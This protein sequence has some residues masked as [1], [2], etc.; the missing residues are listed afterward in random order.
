MSIAF[1]KKTIWAIVFLLILLIIGLLVFVNPKIL[2]MFSGSK[3]L[4]YKDIPVFQ[5]IG[6]TDFN[7]LKYQR[8]TIPVLGYTASDNGSFVQPA[9]QLV[10]LDSAKNIASISVEDRRI[11]DLSVTYKCFTQGCL[12]SLNGSYELS[13][14]NLYFI[15][16]NGLVKFETSMPVNGGFL[17]SASD[18]FLVVDKYLYIIEF[19][20]ISRIKRYDIYTGKLDLVKD[21]PSNVTILSMDSEGNQLILYMYQD[22]KYSIVSYDSNMNESHRKVIAIGSDDTFVENDLSR[23]HMYVLGDLAYLYGE[24]TKKHSLLTIN[25]KNSDTDLKEISTNQLGYVF[26]SKELGK[27]YAYN[28]TSSVVKELGSDNSFHEVVRF[29]NDFGQVQAISNYL[30]L[31]SDRGL[32]IFDLNNKSRKDVKIFNEVE[33]SSYLFRYSPWIEQ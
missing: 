4:L 7:G 20:D 9:F 27:L 33:G 2:D 5:S 24:R 32:E 22:G 19:T 16:Q 25:Y 10:D 6:K 18:K 14:N 17:E 30:L 23:M 31:T 21:N 1:G 28:V 15:S 3:E 8:G 13:L 11:E 29:E 26:T 12:Y